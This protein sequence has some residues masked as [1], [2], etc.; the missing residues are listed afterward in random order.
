MTPAVD[1]VPAEFTALPLASTRRKTLVPVASIDTQRQSRRWTD[2]AGHTVVEVVIDHVTGSD[3]RETDRTVHW[4]EA[5][6]ELGS[7]PPEL[8]DLIETGLT[9]LGLHRSRSASKLARLLGQPY[10]RP[11]MLPADPTAG[12]LVRAYL[13]AQ[14]AAIVHQDVGVR[15]DVAD[16]VHRTRMA[17]RRLCSTCT[18]FRAVLDAKWTAALGEELRWLG[19]QL[20]AARDADVQRARFADADLDA[21]ARQL[22]NEHFD[23]RQRAAKGEA[24]TALNSN[25][26]LRLLDALDALVADPPFTELAAKPPPW[27]ARSHRSIVR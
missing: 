21:A 18:V 13:A 9:E 1:G 3:L 7:G 26:Y 14:V 2:T 5:E 11:I 24:I 15:C 8:L 19:N 17:I 12:D 25:R 16:A 4:T 6:V 10:S 23:R 20:G 27:S 22:L